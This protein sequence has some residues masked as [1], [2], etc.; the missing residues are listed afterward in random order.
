M[1]PPD[2]DL[3]FDLDEL[4]G[5]FGEPTALSQPE[6]LTYWFSYERP[7]GVK[8]ILTL[9]GYE[10]SV[11]IIV[12]L[13]DQVAATAVHLERCDAVRVLEPDRKTLEI[14]G[15][16]PPARCFLALDGDQILDVNI[17]H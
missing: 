6:L 15:E 4:V 17:R 7:D 2:V 5:A 12:R 3:A 11:G 13:S 10:R 16:E 8:I 14:T 9:S 1:S